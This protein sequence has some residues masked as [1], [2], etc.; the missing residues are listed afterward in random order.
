MRCPGKTWA[1][2][3][4]PENGEPPGLC[5][6]QTP[7]VKRRPHNLLL[8]GADSRR[9]ALT[10][11]GPRRR[12]WLLGWAAAAGLPLQWGWAG[13][14][15]LGHSLWKGGGL[16]GSDAQKALLASCNLFTLLPACPGGRTFCR[17]LLQPGTTTSQPQLPEIWTAPLSSPSPAPS[18]FLR[19]PFKKKKPK[20]K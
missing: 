14:V 12:G 11:P 17:S 19:L 2:G 16:P 15:C 18:P 1:W 6:L 20:N 8:R 10:S 5:R 13:G 7:G 4:F 9:A 3:S